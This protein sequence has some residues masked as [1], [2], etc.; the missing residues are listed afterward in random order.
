MITAGVWIALN[1]LL[2][3][4]SNRRTSA[5]GRRPEPGE[6]GLHPRQGQGRPRPPG[7]AGAD[8]RGPRR[9]AP[10]PPTRPAPAR[11]IPGARPPRP[12]DGRPPP[13]PG[14]RPRPSGRLP[15]DPD[16]A[17]PSTPPIERR[18]SV[19]LSMTGF[20]EARLQDDRWSVGVEVRTVN[21]RHL[22]L[23]AKISDPYGALE[24]DLERLVRETI[25]RGTVQ[26]SIRVE[27]P[28]RAED[29]RLNR[30][31]LASYQ[32]SQLGRDP[33][34]GPAAEVRVDLGPPRSALPG[35]RRGAQAGRPTTRTRIGPPWPPWSSEA[36][37]KLQQ[38]RAEEG[39]AMAD[40]LLGLGRA[41]ADHLDGSP[42][43]ARR[44]SPPTRSG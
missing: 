2:V 3:V 17:L 44:S 7:K 9:A 22:K 27:R 43:G 15:N 29:Y 36:L 31:A 20:G 37:A 24:P 8:A 14:G 21:N 23:N 28:R 10:T 34:R 38:A 39:R 42:P 25:R 6:V 19:L 13:I 35:D 4:L 16:S 26:L 30:V 18:A 1:M 12:G 11:P 32:R 5:W 41:V 33:A 40:E